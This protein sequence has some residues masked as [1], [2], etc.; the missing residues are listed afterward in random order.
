MGEASSRM[1]S[2][3]MSQF[4][5]TGGAAYRVT[6]PPLP[7]ALDGTMPPPPPFGEAGRLSGTRSGRGKR[8]GAAPARPVEP[9]PPLAAQLADRPQPRRRIHPR[10]V[11]SAVQLADVLVT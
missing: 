5:A 6:P 11:A 8:L 4:G 10:A 7:R 2:E 9:A 1:P 3:R